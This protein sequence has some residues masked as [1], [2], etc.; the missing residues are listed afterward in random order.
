MTVNCQRSTVESA[1]TDAELRR[2]VEQLRELRRPCQ[3]CPRRCGVDRRVEVGFCGQRETLAVVAA[4]PHRGEEPPLCTGAGAGTIFV[5]GCNMRCRFCQ[6]HQIS[7]GS[8]RPAWSQDV[9]ALARRLIELE[10]AGCA[11][12]EWVSPTPHLPELV[13]ALRL[14][15]AAGAARVPVVYNG[16]GYDRLTVLR[17]L[18]GI[19]DV[20]LPDAKYG[21]AELAEECSSTAD[22]VEVNRRALR[23]MWRQVGP[24]RL[25]AGRAVRGLLVRHLVLPGQLRNTEEVLRWIAEEL[26][27]ELSVSLMA[28]Y[29]PA[30]RTVGAEGPLGRR[31]TRRE[32]RRAVEALSAAGLERGWVQELSSCARFLP[33]FDRADPFG[34]PGDAGAPARPASGC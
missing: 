33:D 30:H 1:L 8:A 28:Q 17:L 3:L 23:E 20:Y 19:V 6:N 21:L 7:Q 2:R 9:E 12:I 27:C 10:R 13:E 11:N 5:A 14:A 26:G 24:L 29:H 16:N 4:L 22:Y 34:S 18:E 25:D 31:I 32:Y 15:R